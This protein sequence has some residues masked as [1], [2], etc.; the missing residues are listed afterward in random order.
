MD[1]S[2]T[3]LTVSPVAE[4]T[5]AWCLWVGGWGLLGWLWLDG[6]SIFPGST[7]YAAVDI[8]YKVFFFG[9]LGLLGPL[10]VAYRSYRLDVDGDR[11]FVRSWLCGK[12]YEYTLNDV[13]EVSRGGNGGRSAVITVNFRDGRLV[14]VR[15]NDRGASELRARLGS[16]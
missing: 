8:A 5:A 10:G 7:G 11:M 15:S 2:R 3:T 16:R 12:T 6:E 14:R 4:L 1:S 13:T 9:V